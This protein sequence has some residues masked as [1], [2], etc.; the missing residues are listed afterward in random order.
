MS[1]CFHLVG[2]RSIEIKVKGGYYARMHNLEKTQIQEPVVLEVHS[3]AALKVGLEMAATDQRRW[4]PEQANNDARAVAKEWRQKTT[5]QR[6]LG[7][8][9]ELLGR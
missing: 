8:A 4:T 1:G 3:L 2:Q 6:Y 9:T 5:H 7:K